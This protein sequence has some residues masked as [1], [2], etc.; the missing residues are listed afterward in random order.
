MKSIPIV[1]FA[2]NRSSHFKRVMISIQNNNIK[3]KIYIILDG[4]KNKKDKVNQTEIIGSIKPFGKYNKFKK[5]QIT[6]IKNKKNLG[7]AKS[8]IQGLNK[9]SKLTDSFI[10]LEDDVVPYSN[11]INFFLRCL[12][13]YKDQN[14][15][16]ICAYQFINFDKNTK[17][18]ET[19]FLKHFIPWGWATWSKN[20][21]EYQNYKSLLIN[22]NNNSIP[23]FIKKIRKKIIKK[24]NN[25]WSIDFMLYNYFNNKFF[26]FPNHSLVKNIGFDGTGTNSVASN[27]LY[28]YEKNI[29]KMVFKKFAINKKD[30][31][32]QTV[33]LKKVINLFY[34]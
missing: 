27:K 22:E 4:A 8:I 1:I 17:K 2:Y 25:Y 28:V 15:G 30:I 23:L 33:R 19:R 13:K 14:I 29:K 6:L 20:W 18:I 3:N 12:E 9:I 16:A 26:I 24:K 11:C 21:R 32:N 5:N 7:L 10:V 31:S 34:K